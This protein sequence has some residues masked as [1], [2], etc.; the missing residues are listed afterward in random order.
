MTQILDIEKKIISLQELVT[1]MAD[2]KVILQ[3]QIEQNEYVQD[4][5]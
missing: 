3:V 1:I 4:N 2:E 5:F